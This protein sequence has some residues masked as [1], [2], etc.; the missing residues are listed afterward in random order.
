MALQPSL[1]PMIVA[2]EY[3][4]PH[5]LDIFLDYVCPFS[6]KL[7]R[8]IDT[9]LKPWFDKGGQYHG[10][11]KLIMRLQVQPWH[12]SS[13]FTHEAGLA[14][15][16]VSPEHF[17]AFSRQLFDNQGD[18]FDIPTSTMTPV[19]IREE[20]AN[21]AA[22]I[23]PENK[24]GEFKELLK[25]KGSPNGGVAVTD[26]LKYTI[27]FSRQ[28]GVHV[29][30]TALWDGLVANEISSSWGEAEWSKFLSEKVK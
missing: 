12:A 14:V 9:V 25:L 30:P 15:A 27:K 2:G 22:K 6:A 8:T 4:A 23:I 11:V 29:S 3:D 10:R 7:S 19:Q 21:L 16:R 20:L 5:T 24:V 18:F 28:N 17:W 1:H 13:T 26:D